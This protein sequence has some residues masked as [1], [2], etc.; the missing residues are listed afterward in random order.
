MS[1][2]TLLPP[3]TKS[4]ADEVNDE[5]EEQLL[6]DFLC[7]GYPIETSRLD[8]KP[9]MEE[10]GIL[11]P[12]FTDYEALELL[13]EEY[14][15]KSYAY[16]FNAEMASKNELAAAVTFP[17]Q[18]L[19]AKNNNTLAR[20]M[21]IDIFESLP[22]SNPGSNAK[23]SFN[24]KF[25]EEQHEKRSAEEGEQKINAATLHNFKI[26]EES[27]DD[28]PGN[29]DNFGSSVGSVQATPDLG[30][31]V[32]SDHGSNYS[33]L[34]E[35]E[36]LWIHHPLMGK[37]VVGIR[38]SFAKVKTS[39]YDAHPPKV[40]HRGWISRRWEWAP[41]NLRCCQTVVRDDGFRHQ[42]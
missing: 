7:R 34:T 42:K 24:T 13:D 23:E 20:Y 33:S 1:L 30:S 19:T 31:S 21:S 4:W 15:I 14:T 10:A 16:A 17:G 36:E 26:W 18:V 35:D 3:L 6:H 29:L 40:L 41:S 2:A 28:F 39:E 12:D 5:L 25:E 27:F 37:D 32:F 38:E 11:P 9:H 8:Q 22:Y